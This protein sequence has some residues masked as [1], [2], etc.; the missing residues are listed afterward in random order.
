MTYDDLVERALVL[1][2]TREDLHYGGTSVMR[3]DRWMLS[4]KKDGETI[5]LKLD[6]ESHDRL[7][8]THPETIFKTPHYEG[9]PAFLVRL[10]LLTPDLAEELIRLS[11]EDAPQKAKKIR[12]S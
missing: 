4:L 8:A 6:W 9:Y 12:S 10:D 11:W 1:P 2:D 3:G 7:L 5:V